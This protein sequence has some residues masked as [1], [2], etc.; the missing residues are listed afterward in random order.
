M[1]NA[2]LD[3]LTIST[4]RDKQSV[5]AYLRGKAASTP[6]FQYTLMIT[7]IFT[8]WAVDAFYGFD[9]ESCSVELFGHADAQVGVTSIADIAR[10]T[11]D[12][13]HIQ[14]RGSERVLR[15]QG[16]RGTLRSLIDALEA[17]RDRKYRIRFVS[18]EDARTKQE[19]ARLA[20]DD[21]T[22]MMFSIKPLLGSG[23]GVA[24][25]TDPLDNDLFNFKP[26]QPVDTFRRTF[27]AATR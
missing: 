13:L 2:T 8:E 16:W 15:V 5:R 24:D 22:E 14:F 17:A 7:A 12:S 3:L 21:L 9:H 4:V 25:G 20:R 11:V 26:E 23:F 18:P 1:S 10:Y 19:E 27:G 6:G